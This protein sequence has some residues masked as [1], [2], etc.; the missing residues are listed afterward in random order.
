MAQ[1]DNTEAN[2]LAFLHNIIVRRVLRCMLEF[3][4]THNNPHRTLDEYIEQNGDQ[5]LESDLGR[6]HRQI[7]FPRGH[8]VTMDMLPVYLIEFL[9]A[10]ESSLITR[11]I[12]DV[13]HE[14]NQKRKELYTEIVTGVDDSFF[15][16][17]LEKVKQLLTALCQFMKNGPL[18]VEI[19]EQ[20]ANI[21]QAN[22]NHTDDVLNEFKHQQELE[23]SHRKAITSFRDADE[24]GRD[25]DEHVLP[26]RPED[27]YQQMQVPEAVIEIA[28]QNTDQ[29][30]NV[31]VARDIVNVINSHDEG[32][33]SIA[34]ND[35]REKIRDTVQQTFS[36]YG[37]FYAR[38]GCI[39][40]R[41]K[42]KTIKHLFKL[43]E[44]CVS[45]EITKQLKPIEDIIRSIR[46]CENYRQNA[47]LYNDHYDSVM[48]DIASQMCR[49]LRARGLTLPNDDTLPKVNLSPDGNILVRVAC[50]SM[51]ERDE[52]ANAITDGKFKFLFRTLEDNCRNAFEAPDIVLNATVLERTLEE[53]VYVATQIEVATPDAVCVSTNL[54]S[55]MG[56]CLGRGSQDHLLLRLVRDSVFDSAKLFAKY[57][58]DLWIWNKF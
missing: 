48:N 35:N 54:E 4:V 32:V 17:H 9:I 22:E 11:D 25:S 13:L 24:P 27:K 31:Q 15:R 12:K 51:N 6:R 30:R 46:N 19:Q 49:L 47:V 39:Q 23:K 45:G 8:A 20:T 28:V 52:Y 21:N 43:F 41:V 44:D 26:P 7:L 36:Y 16:G 38:Q 34:G 40:I 5:I 58:V 50:P 3:L 1:P 14:L 33:A 2:A 57:A 55:F 37:E 56:K 10:H 42:P 29:T 18:T 53:T